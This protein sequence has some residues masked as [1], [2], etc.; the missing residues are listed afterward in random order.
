MSMALKLGAL[1]R[2]QPVSAAATAKASTLD[3][4]IS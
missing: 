2:S 4:R 1:A 3:Q